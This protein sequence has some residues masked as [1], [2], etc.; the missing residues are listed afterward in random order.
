MDRISAGAVGRIGDGLSV[1]RKAGLATV[2]R[3]AGVLD[4]ASAVGADGPDLERTVPIGLEDKPL[5]IGRPVRLGAIGEIIGESL[6]RT[7]GNGQCPDN[8]EQVESQGLAV[9]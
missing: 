3:S 9:G 8:A 7:A 1:R 4:E 5:P 6:R 2:E